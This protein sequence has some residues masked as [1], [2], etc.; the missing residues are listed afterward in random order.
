L[1]GSGHKVDAFCAEAVLFV[2]GQIKM[3]V[4]RG[5]G[6]LESQMGD[7][8]APAVH[9]QP[10]W[11]SKGLPHFFGHFLSLLVWPSSL[12]FVGM[13][14][15][16][17]HL[18]SCLILCLLGLSSFAQTATV[19][20]KVVDP[21][22]QPI[23]GVS[24]QVLETDLRGRSDGEGRYSLTLPA[25][26]AYR[27]RFSHSGHRPSVLAIEVVAD[28]VYDEPIKLLEIEVEGVNIYGDKDPT[29]ISDETM[30]VSPISMEEIQRMPMAAPSVEA[31]VKGMPGVASNNEFSSQYQ[32]RGGNFDENLVYVNGIE[33]YRPFLT[34]SGQ[35]EGLGFSNPSMAENLKFSTGGFAPRYGDKLS[36]VL[37]ITYRQPRAFKASAEVGIISTNLHAE[38]I[39][40]NKKNPEQ[41]GKFTWLV[42]ARRFAMAYLLNSLNTT[43]DYRPS[44]LDG[45]A[46]FTY[47]PTY[48][49]KPEKVVTR[50]NGTK[51]TIYYDNTPVKIT[52]FFAVSRNRYRFEPTGR[53]STIGTL[54]DVVLRIRTGFEGREISDYTTGLGAL[55]LE[56]QPSTRWKFDYILTAFRT[57]ERELFDVEGGYL[58]GEVNTNLNDDEFNETSFDLDIGSQFRHARN[59]LK[60]TVAS[61][62]A[63][64]RWLSGNQARHR[65]EF[66]VK[67]QYQ[68]IDDDI[69]EYSLFDSAGYVIDPLGQFSNQE[70]IRGET[71]LA[72]SQYKAFIQHE[73]KVS[74]R[75][76]LVYGA[77]A[78]YYDLIDELMISPRGQVIV[79]LR[80]SAEGELLTRL[81]LAGGLYHQPPFYRELRRFNG[82]V[83]LDVRSQSAAHAIVGLDHKF[84][85]WNRPF[86]LVAEAYYKS[87]YHLIP[88]EVQNVRIRYYPDEVGVGYAYGL[89]ARLNGEF[90]K[91]VDSWVSVGLLKTAENIEGD[92]QGYVPRPTDQRLT[93]S[94]YFQDE[95]PINPT[96]KVH[97]NYNY[98][99]GMRFGPPEDFARRTAFGFP[100]YHRVDLGFSKL[101]T[102]AA[103]SRTGLESVWITLEV[104]NLLQRSNTVSFVWIKD[105]QNQ[106]YAVPNYL[107]ARLINARVIFRFR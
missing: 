64:G 6:G 34:R 42:G 50:K 86:R 99:S 84:T 56:H 59:Y 81:R 105:L 77:R 79:D 51:D 89:D 83:N 30:L 19:K 43:G 17:K 2:G 8:N 100:P 95:L 57:N 82:T 27:I 107:S 76:R 15:L 48:Q 70:Y 46:M 44:F 75:V 47:T 13:K 65:L 69:K 39:S 23:E 9:V 35:Q 88:Y 41:P 25:G 103:G 78:L 104:F 37:D 97:I 4:G 90:I 60:A 52:S 36:S 91:G 72:S 1:S 94:M 87:L 45:Q 32:V 98:G 18:L 102:L 74:R 68:Y 63:R 33:I 92:E 54:T 26:Q 53:V 28:R 12:I 93:F 10:F 67:Y 66:G 29:S 49:N 80:R 71:Q 55:M 106:Q 11:P 61:A 101:I 85:A 3:E 62:Q 5:A 20:G 40:K 58:L 21:F 7:G 38:G 24:I 22:N 31:F 14:H 96:Y 73:W 16:P